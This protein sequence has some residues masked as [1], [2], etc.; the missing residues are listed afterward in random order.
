[1]AAAR[2]LKPGQLPEFLQQK[3]EE[4]KLQNEIAASESGTFTLVI[5]HL[6]IGSHVYESDFRSA[7]SQYPRNHECPTMIQNPQ[8][9]ISPSMMEMLATSKYKSVN[10]S[11]ILILIDPQYLRD[12]RLIGLTSVYPS[13]EY[14][15][16]LVIDG[17]L[18]TPDERVLTDA[19][20]VMPFTATLEP[21]VLPYDITEQDALTAMKCLTDSAAG[22]TAHTA[23]LVNCMDCTS[24]TMRRTWIENDDPR[25][26]LAMPDCLAVDSKPEYMPVATFSYVSF[27][28]V[29]N[30]VRWCNWYRDKDLIPIYQLTSP[31]TYKFMIDS[32]NAYIMNV[33]MIGFTKLVSRMS[34]T[35][36]YTLS[37][38]IKFTFNTLSQSDFCRYWLDATRI[39]DEFREHFMS[40]LDPYFTNNIRKF[41]DTIVKLPIPAGD[42]PKPITQI[43]LDYLSRITEE[44][45]QLSD[46]STPA[47][48]VTPGIPIRELKSHIESYLNDHGIYM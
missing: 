14:N 32:F 4:V 29:R 42:E 2:K 21:V 11:Q 34:V 20:P 41:V 3:L 17:H 31:S 12:C 37:N 27:N 33:F 6:I 24:H 46:G 16:I 36:E 25:I 26:Y 5:F 23:I 35:R 10:I 7:A 8:S 30:S 1:M 18:T 48:Q 39:G 15:P 47:F 28:A 13:F 38:G 40:Y 44:F 19:A 45:K 22:F 9:L 43:A